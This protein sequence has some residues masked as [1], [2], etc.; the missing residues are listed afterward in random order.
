M[1][2]QT[3]STLWSVKDPILWVELLPE[4]LDYLGLFMRRALAE[5]LASNPELRRRKKLRSDKDAVV[6]RSPKKNRRGKK[7]KA[8]V[9]QAE[10]ESQQP[11]QG[12]LNDVEEEEE[13]SADGVIRNILDS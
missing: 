7:R 10:E 12:A 8:V 11:E 1:P 9:E 13:A 4:N 5:H 6:Q 3:M 2:A